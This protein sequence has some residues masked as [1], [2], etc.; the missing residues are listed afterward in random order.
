MGNNT[1]PPA[2][3]TSPLPP[4]SPTPK[5]AWPRPGVDP[6]APRLPWADFL[7]LVAQQATKDYPGPVGRFLAAR[8][9]SL[10]VEAI[11]LCANSPEEHEHLSQASADAE[12]AWVAA[13]R[14][15]I[16]NLFPTAHR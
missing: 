7:H 2:D 12:A 15:R 16:A 9:G 3:S 13:N 5:F 10:M 6:E 4:P 11:D 1:Q 8:I 14:Q